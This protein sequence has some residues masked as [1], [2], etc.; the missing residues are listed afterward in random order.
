MEY[1]KL[2]QHIDRSII[3]GLDHPHFSHWLNT[4][5]VPL[6]SLGEIYA[7]EAYTAAQKRKE[8]ERVER[9]YL[10]KLKVLANGK[11]AVFG[12]FIFLKMMR[13]GSINYGAIPELLNVRLEE[14]RK[15]EVETW[16][17]TKK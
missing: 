5:E 15:T 7:L 10:D 11:T 14:Y 2:D 13:A 17:L 9:E 8:F 12:E 4:G 3:E 6:A 16:T 1:I